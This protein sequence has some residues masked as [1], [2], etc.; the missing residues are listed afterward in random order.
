MGKLGRPSKISISQTWTP[1]LAYAIGL[2]A[3]D[4]CLGEYFNYVNLTSKD[5]EQIDNFSKCLGTKFAV[6]KKG[7]GSGAA[8][9]YFVIQFKNKDFYEFLVSIGLTPRKSKTL[10]PLKIPAQY[11]WDFLRGVYDGDGS[12]NAYWDPRWRSSYMFYT[13][14]ASASNVFAD[15]LREEIRERVGVVG[16]MTRAGAGGVL[17]QLRYAKKDSLIILRK[18]YN[19]KSDICLSRKRLK[20]QGILS[21]VGEK[22]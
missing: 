5:R 7:N 10:G 18:M 19:A 21:T 1:D 2:I 8:K 17:Y 14:F 11:F 3:T 12:S 22:L 4:G 9:I 6:G 20:I 16:H 13:V 15:W